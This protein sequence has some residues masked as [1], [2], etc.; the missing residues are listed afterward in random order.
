MHSSRD[1]V[2]RQTLPADGASS[3]VAS[4]LIILSFVLAVLYLGRAVLEPLAIAVLL[5]FILAPPIRHLR[6]Y[7]I[8]RASSVIIVVVLA[9]AFIGALG[10]LMETQITRLAGELPQYQSNLS[11]KIS[12]LNNALVPS[13]ALKRASTTLNS[14]SAELKDRRNGSAD[15]NGLKRQPAAPI[16]VEV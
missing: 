6:Q 14:L 8:G 3:R 4:A 15:D 2:P 7:H 10:F 16:P 11:R 9:L 13:G 1:V 5:G 12:S